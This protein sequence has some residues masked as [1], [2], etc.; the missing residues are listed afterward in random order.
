MTAVLYRQDCLS[1]LFEEKMEAP[2]SV[3]LS[4]MFF[5][6][7]VA[8]A[9]SSLVDDRTLRSC[10]IQEREGAGRD[11]ERGGGEERDRGMRERA[12]GERGKG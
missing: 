5:T 12:D 9:E 1:F 4:L 2:E 6:L 10:Q 11:R 7:S 8:N 3:T